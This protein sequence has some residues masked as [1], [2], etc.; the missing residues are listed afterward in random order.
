MCLAEALLRMPDNDTANELV[1]DKLQNKGW[2]KYL[3]NSHSLFVNAS[4]WGL[5]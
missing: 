2:K 5:F 4:S 1:K 3:E